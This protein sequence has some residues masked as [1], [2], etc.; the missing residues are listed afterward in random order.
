MDPATVFLIANNGILI[1]WLLLIAAPN[2]R[3]TRIAAHSIAVPAILGLTYLWLILSFWSGPVPQG[4]GYGSLTGVMT[5]LASPVA[6]T[7]GWIHY[8]CFDLFVGAW[9]ARD[10]RRRGVPHWLVVPCLLVTL[11]AG[12]VG[13][14]GYLGLRLS[15][16]KGGFFLAEA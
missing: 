15:L 2:W 11:L 13:L 7:A 6:A 10:A 9:L 8:L 1:F 4:A 3:G 5:F 12:P 16:G 14:I